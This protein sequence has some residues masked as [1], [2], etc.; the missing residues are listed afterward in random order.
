MAPESVAEPPSNERE[1]SFPAGMGG[2]QVEEEILAFMQSVP[3][4]E[5]IFR[6]QDLDRFGPAADVEQALE[7]L[8]RARKVGSPSDGVWFPIHFVEGLDW[9][10]PY[11]PLRQLALSLLHREGVAT[12]VSEQ[13]RQYRLFHATNGREGV[14]GVPNFEAIGVEEPAPLS[15]WWNMGCAY[16]EQQENLFNMSDSFGFTATEIIDPRK[17]RRRAEQLDINPE[18]IEKDIHVNSALEGFGLAPWPAEGCLLFA[19]GTSLVKAW[20]LSPRFSEDVD[21]WYLDNAFPPDVSDDK[22]QAVHA[23]LLQTLQQWVIPRIQGAVLDGEKS[24]YRQGLPVQRGFVNFPSCFGEG[25]SGTLKLEVMFT[26]FAPSWTSMA[27]ESLPALSTA[28]KVLVDQYPCVDMWATM[29][30]KMHALTL[31][32]PDENFQD[33]RHVHDLGTWRRRAPHAPH[34][35]FMVQ[36]AFAENRIRDLLDGL[37]PALEMLANNEACQAAYRQ[38]LA[39]MYPSSHRFGTP[40]LEQ[41]VGFVQSLWQAM[42]DSDWDNP[43]YEPEPVPLPSEAEFR[44]SGVHTGESEPST[45]L[46]AMREA[47]DA[48]PSDQAAEDYADYWRNRKTGWWDR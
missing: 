18:R 9:P 6:R 12:G 47:A 28:S 33:M 35:P 5:R 27:I 4:D 32:H 15:L 46:Q 13:E 19:G 26:R 30:G 10:I 39:E 31:M 2:C 44:A 38:Y 7:R 36:Q 8:A 23:H 25:E 45:S 11:A 40:T 1:C 22:K 37:L 29:L 48:A 34:C 21:F 20:G 24:A 43:I 41:A 17:L 16:T 42:C 14:W 3:P